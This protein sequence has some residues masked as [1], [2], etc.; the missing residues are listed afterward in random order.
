MVAFLAALALAPWAHP[1][2]FRSLL[3]WQTGMSGTHSAYVRTLLESSAWIARGVRYR[4]DATADP[5][6]K[7][8]KH[9]PRDGVIVWAVID[10]PAQNGTKPIRLDVGK[11]KRFACCE[12]AY[13]AGG[14][15]ELTGSGPGRGYY[16]I[17]RIYFGSRPTGSLRAA[18]Q[19]ALDRLELPAPR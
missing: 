12:G 10:N 13:V 16:V 19:Q 3:G 6:N 1:L 15:Y 4:D 11:A 5:P 8:L 9:L 14:E 18:A 17:V 2:A 7:T